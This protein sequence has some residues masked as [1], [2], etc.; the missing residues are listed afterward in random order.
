MGAVAAA[1]RQ[2]HCRGAACGAEVT[3]S[4]GLRTHAGRQGSIMH[5]L[6]PLWSRNCVR[7]ESII[8]CLGALCGLS[9][10]SVG[11][12]SPFCTSAL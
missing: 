1:A 5:Q 9:G 2:G 12:I 10:S 11:L 6:L 8:C 3:G 7:V 4:A